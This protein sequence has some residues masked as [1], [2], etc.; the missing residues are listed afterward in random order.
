MLL[1]P[2]F[3]S[4]TLSLLVAII[5]MTRKDF[6]AVNK[7]LSAAIVLTVVVQSI[8]FFIMATGRLTDY[9]YLFRLGCPFYYL[10][11]PLIYIYVTSI[12]RK[13]RKSLGHYL[14]HFVP[15]A[16]SVIDIGWYYAS[17]TSTYRIHEISLIRNISSAE[18]QLGA[19]FLPSILHYYARF[20]QRLYYIAMQWLVL[21]EEKAFSKITSTT[22]KWTIVLTSA[23][24]VI[25]IGYGY[26][27]AQIF[28][29]D[30]SK[31]SNVFDSAKDISIFIML[32]GMI[33]ICLYLFTHP[34]ILYGSIFPRSKQNA[35]PK[36]KSIENGQYDWLP[37][38]TNIQEYCDRLESFMQ[39]QKPFLKKRIS[40]GLVANEAD[41]PAHL[42]SAILNKHYGKSF[43][44]FVN[45]YRINHILNR[46][47]EDSNW[48]QLTMEGIALDAGFSSRTGFYAA[49]KK[50]TGS[51]PGAYLSGLA[52]QSPSFNEQ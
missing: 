4:V 22:H 28:L 41:V 26:F 24:T 19:G 52:E 38:G 43:S 37:A 7:W 27:T 25:L 1:L 5:F 39:I 48:D 11:P 40:L 18:L 31:G 20:F 35:K 15:F 34:E 30:R 45:E 21:V 10:T 2:L 17:T 33:L 8:V 16:I 3:L 29:F 46:I 44:D 12:L 47:K 32:V 13:K 23:Q 9:W 36:V 51:S 50:H 6:D 42:L 49:F 14:I